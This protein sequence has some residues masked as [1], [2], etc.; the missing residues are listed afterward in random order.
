MEIHHRLLHAVR[1]TVPEGEWLVPIG[2]S[3]VKRE[4]KDVTVVAIAYGVQKALEAAVKAS[5]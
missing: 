5:Q 2:V 4:G 3:D 1:Q